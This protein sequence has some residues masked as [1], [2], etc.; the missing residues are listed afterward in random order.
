MLARCA[1]MSLISSFVGKWATGKKSKGGRLAGR[2]GRNEEEG[3]QNLVV[4]DS[5]AESSNK[6]IQHRRHGDGVHQRWVHLNR[7]RENRK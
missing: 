2:D 4:L 1:R 5:Q 7:R 3:G 6:L